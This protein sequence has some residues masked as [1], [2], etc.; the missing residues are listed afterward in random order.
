MIG[1]LEGKLAAL[2]RRFQLGRIEVLS[3]ESL[4]PDY[5]VTLDHK[6]TGSEIKTKI[7]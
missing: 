1:F 6:G 3:V 7:V 2:I 4:S 5:F